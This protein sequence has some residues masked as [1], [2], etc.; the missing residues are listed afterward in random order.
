MWIIILGVIGVA[1]SAVISRRR[2]NRRGLPPELEKHTA[3]IGVVP[4]WVSILNIVSWGL[5]VLGVLTLVC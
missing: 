4:T 3:G 5:I 1:L 2:L